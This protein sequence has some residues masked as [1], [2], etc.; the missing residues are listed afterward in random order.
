MQEKDLP[1]SSTCCRGYVGQSSPLAAEYH[2]CDFDWYEHA[3]Q[4]APLLA[5]QQGAAERA[6]TGT[7]A[8]QAAGID[9]SSPASELGDTA[10]QPAGSSIP[11][12]ISDDMTASP[13]QPAL[14]LPRDTTGTT[15]SNFT[16]HTAQHSSSCIQHAP[17]ATTP[18][19]PT[20]VSLGEAAETTASGR[21][22]QACSTSGQMNA[23]DND[24]E[25]F[26][27]AHPRARFFKER[28]YL[29][30]EFPQLQPGSGLQHV[31]EIGCG[32]GSAMLPVLK[33]NPQAQATVSDVSS[34]CLEQLKAAAT[35]AGMDM[36][37][38]NAFV[39]DGTDPHLTHRLSGCGADACLIM[40][41]LS[42]VK[43]D[44][45]ATM[46]RNAYASLRPGGVLLIRD[47]GLYDLVQL[48]IPAEQQIGPNL[49]R[50][51]DG[52]LAY[53][54]TK[55]ELSG[56]AE[57]AGF[58]VQECDYVCVINRN[59]KTGQELRRV[60]VHGVFKRTH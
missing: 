26:Y 37:R 57:Q 20:T 44:Q 32:C 48:R 9:H 49:Y 5:A 17:H 4:V 6:A 35:A 1:S 3:K 16:M 52:T 23:Q 30:L 21:S 27:R 58:E 39:A 7:S 2:T 13:A 60:F 59:Q 38:I 45:M 12:N 54:F 43:P 22:S 11:V 46:M 55:E 47:H 33:A 8:L 36:S 14:A 53:F 29:L 15:T 19:Q 40:F 56:L 42:A 28:R 34:T 24:W 10:K 50:M 31:V 41:T 51:G 18:T 25:R